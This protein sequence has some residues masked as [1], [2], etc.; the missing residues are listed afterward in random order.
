MTSNPD[1]RYA[2]RLD[3]ML[4]KQPD[5]TKTDMTKTDLAD[6]VFGREI[7][8]QK[9]LTFAPAMNIATPKNYVLGSGDEVR[10]HIWGNSEQNIVQN[11][12][13]EGLVFIENLGPVKLGGLTV[14]AAEVRLK[15]ELTE[16]YSGLDDGSITAS[17]SVG[18]TRS[19]KINVV[20]EAFMPGTYT[21]PSFST[22]MHALY[23]AG[24]VNDIGSLRSV[25][26]YR[27]N[28]EVSVLDVYDFL[29]DGVSSTNARM[30]DGD[31]VVI[32]PYES[33]V[34]ARGE[35]KRERIYEMLNGE[36]LEDLLN[37]AGGFN[38]SAYS[39]RVKIERM[40]GESREIKTVAKDKFDSFVMVDGDILTV[41]EVA[42]KY[43]NRI[44]VEGAVWYPGDY[45]LGEKVS[46]VRGLVE[47]AAGLKGDEFLGRAHITRIN[48]DFT[49]TV[50]AV[51]IRGIMS[52]T[53]PDVA[54]V[55]D[56]SLYIPAITDL[57]KEYTIKVFGAV[58]TPN[59]SIN[60]RS[61]MS[62]EDAIIMAG[63]LT[64]AAAVV[65]VDISRRVKD[66]KSTSTPSRIVEVFTVTL[67]DGLA[68]NKDGESVILEP[69]DEVYVRY[70][71][72][73]R[74]QEVVS[75]KGEILFKGDYVLKEVNSRLS[76]VV[77]DA[78][79]VTTTGYIKGANL[80]RQMSEDEV[81]KVKMILDMAKGAQSDGKDSVAVSMADMK[82]Y[83]VGIDL[84]KALK[85]PGGPD[86]IVLRDGDVLTI[87]KQ[88]STVKI[89][90][91]VI[92]SN[93]VTYTPGMS[94]KDCLRQAGG[95]SDYAYKRPIVIYMNGQVA[96][97][98]RVCIFF[99]HYPK[100]EPGCQ[101]L[102]PLKRV[103]DRTTGEILAITNSTIAMAAMVTTLINNIK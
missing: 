42:E 60:F 56:D 5:M 9:E 96:S 95:Y 23:A 81:H 10:I 73:Y 53:A 92:Y 47:Q 41:D 33:L 8:R 80:I 28:K 39:E 22:I 32:A 30:E 24:G 66:P 2:P 64:E 62:V 101:V 18:Q 85:N 82:T 50:I 25:K 17:L 88:Q 36:S 49:K 97:T 46:T 29:L 11:I 58:N 63:G 94:V 77:R 43:D 59:D 69:F 19:I 1:S 45:E 27:N 79:G 98:R 87:P 15:R 37:M 102:V 26:L 20:G 86:D 12:S 68:L 89:D 76:D 91:G 13:P 34:K 83:S 21:L 72:G 4:V 7:F 38:G 54:L 40:G 6:E 52:G 84:E 90:G 61:D 71:P 99:K 93:S 75:I 35:V 31:M 100:I 48:P 16:I 57:R 44:T 70:S 78:G 3:T 55:K 65:N 14:E 74:K 51:D 103:K 67:Q